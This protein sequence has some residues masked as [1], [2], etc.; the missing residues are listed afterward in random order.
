M[1][2]SSPSRTITL[3][4]TDGYRYLGIQP[5]LTVEELADLPAP[6]SERLAHFLQDYRSVERFEED[7]SVDVGFWVEGIENH[8]DEAFIQY[9]REVAT[10]LGNVQ[11]FETV[12]PV[13][14]GS[15][16]S[17]VLHGASPQY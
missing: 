7:D 12:M 1:A 6:R 17:Q 13:G 8:I 2:E 16:T 10:Y 15:T 4:S 11:L 5:P 9:S 3:G 14:P